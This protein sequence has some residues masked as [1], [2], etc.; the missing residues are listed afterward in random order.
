MSDCRSVSTRSRL[1]RAR[2]RRDPTAGTSFGSQAANATG[3]RLGSPAARSLDGTSEPHRRGGHPIRRLGSRHDVHHRR[4]CC[5]VS[6]RAAAHRSTVPVI[7][8]DP[9][10]G[11]HTDSRGRWRSRSPRFAP[12]T[13]PLARSHL[14]GAVE[15]P[16]TFGG[17]TGRAPPPWARRRGLG[18]PAPARVPPAQV[19]GVVNV[20]EKSGESF[21]VPRYRSC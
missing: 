3:R 6:D 7:G 18:H 8:V 17:K 20:R 4:V 16:T 14:V 11:S 13:P 9:H 12:G 19:S 5:G 2:P 15:R 21:G 10:K 1:F